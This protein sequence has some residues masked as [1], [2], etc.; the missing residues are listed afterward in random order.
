MP[1]STLVTL[2]EKILQLSKSSH[3][4]LVM[5]LSNVTIHLGVVTLIAKKKMRQS[6]ASNLSTAL[7]TIKNGMS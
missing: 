5:Y 1:N 4:F 6:K 2:D 3:E 7:I